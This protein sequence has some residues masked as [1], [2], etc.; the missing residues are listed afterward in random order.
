MRPKTSGVNMI[1][2]MSLSQTNS[3]QDIAPS[4]LW[5]GGSTVPQAAVD[6]TRCRATRARPCSRSPLAKLTISTGRSWDG[7]RGFKCK[8]SSSSKN[9]YEDTPSVVISMHSF[10][11]TFLITL[12]F[13]LI[14]IHF[15]STLPLLSL[16]Q[17][18]TLLPPPSPSSTASPTT[19]REERPCMI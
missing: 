10:P 12:T 15:L 13:S 2:H 19:R 3:W 9:K 16:T 8:K 6:C 11:C 14:I 17:F 1:A 5:I 7:W 18:F 4:G